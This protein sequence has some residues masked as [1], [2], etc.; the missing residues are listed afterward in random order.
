[1][2]EHGLN[3]IM[4]SIISILRSA[5]MKCLLLGLVS[6][7][8]V[9][10]V[11]SARIP[12]GADA[13]FPYNRSSPPDERDSPSFIRHLFFTVLRS[14]PRLCARVELAFSPL[15]GIG[16]WTQRER[17]RCRVPGSV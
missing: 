16:N 14:T 2:S 7:I 15:S 17:I 1:M 3:S 10:T 6:I 13:L 11:A 8:A 4:H 5:L 12:E 9:G